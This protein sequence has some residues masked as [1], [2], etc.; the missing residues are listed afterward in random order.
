MAASRESIEVDVLFV[1]AGPASLSGAYHL[2]RMLKEEGEG[3]HS[4]KVGPGELSIMVIEKGREVGAHGIS[5]AVLN[6]RGLDE[7]MPGWRDKDPPL[8]GVPVHEDSLCFLA[9]GG[10][11][12]LPVLPSF[13]NNHGNTVVSLSR[14]LRWLLPQVEGVGVDVFPEFPAVELLYQDGGVIGVRTGDKGVGKDGEPKANYE[15]GIDIR[16]RVTILGEGPRGTLAKELIKREGL[17][18]GKNPQSY[19]LGVKEVWEVPGTPLQ[20]GD[21][22]HTLLW[23]LEKDDF[24][25]GFIYS[26]GDGLLSVGMVVGLGS[27]DPYMNVHARLQDFKTHP[28]ISSIL[29]GGQIVEYGAKTIPEGGYYAIPRPYAD[30]VLLVGDSAG[31]L[32]SRALK[33][34]H[35]AVKSGM[36]A[37]ETAYEALKRN[38][39][40]A[41]V[42]K[43]Y[44]R[45]I[46]ESW[47]RDELYPVRNFHQGFAD[48]LWKGLMRMGVQMATGGRGFR[49]PFPSLPDFSRMEKVRDYYGGH[50][51]EREK[52]VYDNRFT[53]DKVTDVYYSGTRHEEDQPPHLRIADYDICNNRC[54]EE[55][56]NPCESFCPANVYEME[57]GED[58][59]RRLNLNPANCVHCKT[60]DVMD[61]Y[62]IITWVPPEGGGGP[63]HQRT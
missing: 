16:A 36:L 14:F 44:E 43:G 58:G 3:E 12:K 30:G 35:L 8:P 6:P 24:G 63:N 4:A 56:G 13:L 11:W 7:L 15:P 23:P 51:R 9:G 29:K 50:W 28:F 21:I 26:M 19:S 1:G 31:F 32:N 5:G 17:E 42:L 61:P 49:D 54:I 20:P 38:D 33:G 45:R 34:I 22:I 52:R 62:Q 48:G 2:A 53:F 47:I 27:R 41:E 39:S 59:A 25:G 37:A 18:E 57:E 46:Q 10:K 60:C 40:S 55:Y